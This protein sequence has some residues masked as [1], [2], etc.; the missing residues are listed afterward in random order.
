MH[1]SI[2]ANQAGGPN[3][4][5]VNHRVVI[6]DPSPM[7]RAGLRNLLAADGRF[8][9]IAESPGTDGVLDM[10]ASAA[11]DLLI[12]DPRQQELTWLEAIRVVA[13]KARLLVLAD[14][15]SRVGEAVRAGADG[16]LLNNVDGQEIIE[17]LEQLIAGRAVLDPHLAVHALRATVDRLPVPEPLTPREL[18]ILRH[19]SQGETNRQIARQLYLAVGTVKVH[20]EHI[21][22]KLGAV[23]RT[24]AA[25]RALSR[26]LLKD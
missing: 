8:E 3:R 13:P 16:V 9:V 17:A 20:V 5:T 1:S 10:L 26:G 6:V 18:E 7:V 4:G 19:V 23:D 24:D 14:A 25:V 2:S 21:L 22:A 15:E 11:P 12:V